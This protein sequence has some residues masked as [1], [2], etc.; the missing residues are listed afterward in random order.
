M[1]FWWF[2]V[3]KEGSEN[4]GEKKGSKEMNGFS[5]SVRCWV[6][7]SPFPTPNSCHA[8]P[9]RPPRTTASGTP[10]RTH[11]RITSIFTRS[12]IKTLK[13]SNTTEKLYEKYLRT[14][15]IK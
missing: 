6:P 4:S 14:Y 7:H 9:R 12:W 8:L 11:R 3:V 2:K 13:R 10:P 1:G 15:K 5:H